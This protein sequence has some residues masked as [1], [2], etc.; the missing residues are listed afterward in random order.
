MVYYRP[1]LEGSWHSV[2]VPSKDKRF[3]LTS[4]ESGTKY[5]VYL[6]AYSE[7]GV[8][9]PSDTLTL[10]TEGKHLHHFTEYQMYFTFKG[11]INTWSMYTVHNYMYIYVSH[12]CA[13][14]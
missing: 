12:R 8:S 2:H 7:S 1:G 14:Y 9:D 6:T 4:L 3:K 11:N 5:Q 13:S 10:L